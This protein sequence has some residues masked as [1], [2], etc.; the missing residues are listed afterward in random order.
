MNP[1]KR[2][3]GYRGVA[4]SLRVAARGSEPAGAGKRVDS[5]KERYRAAKLERKLVKYEALPEYL[6][7]NEFI[8][9]YYRCEWPLKDLLLSVFS[10]HN[11]TLNVWTH[12]GGALIFV[13]LTAM[14]LTEKSSPENLFAAGVF[15]LERM[16]RNKSES[17]YPDHNYH[18]RNLIGS[19]ITD[20][21]NFPMWPWFI[22]LGGATCCL[23]LS[24]VSHLF[25]CHSRRCNLLLWRL[26]QSGISLM[27]VASFVAPIYYV[28][29]CH[30][31]SRVFYFASI[32][33]LGT[34]AA[35]SLLSPALTSGR[36]RSFKAAVFLALGLSGIVPAAHTALLY[37][38]HPQVAAALWCEMAMGV[39]YAAGAAFYVARFPERVGPGKFDLVGSSH[40]IFHVLVV[41][42]AL[43]HCVATL[44]LMDWR[45]GLPHCGG[46]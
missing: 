7:D 11:E 17:I 4:Q 36:F 10:L 31:L 5:A 39:L 28:F 40:Q 32:T 20:N 30:P 34:L 14:S 45:R 21:V 18:Q 29:D 46:A 2:R 44:V 6:Q 9:D 38:H 35:V 25:A 1:M 33:L 23:V 15:R 3:G 19:S 24:S 8:R 37:G 13:A 16:K 43:A 26:D 12:L 41:A 27:V 42:A 22:F